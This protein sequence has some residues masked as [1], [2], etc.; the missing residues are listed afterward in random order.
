ME[1]TFCYL[2]R[3]MINENTLYPSYHITLGKRKCGP[4]VRIL[5]ENT[6]ILSVSAKYLQEKSFIY[7]Q[8]NIS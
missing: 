4:S 3:N 8:K 7:L 2:M 1:R 5:L 6:I